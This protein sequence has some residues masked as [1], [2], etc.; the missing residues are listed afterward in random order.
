[1]CFARRETRQPTRRA[2]RHLWENYRDRF[3]V[4]NEYRLAGRPGRVMIPRPGACHAN[5][6]AERTTEA[7][8]V[9]AVERGVSGLKGCLSNLGLGYPQPGRFVDRKSMTALNP[10]L[11]GV[12]TPRD[13][14]DHS[15]PPIRPPFFD[16]I[17]A[18]KQKRLGGVCRGNPGLEFSTVN[19]SRRVESVYSTAT[20]R[21]SSLAPKHPIQ[22][23]LNSP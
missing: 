20:Q 9:L 1:L 8:T 21:A 15:H 10:N 7:I 14:G 2:S 18:S 12:R 16:P 4:Y 6:F 3:V 13:S 5:G 19:N 22:S 17:D 11:A 23:V